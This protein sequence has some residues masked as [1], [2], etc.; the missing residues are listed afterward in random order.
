LKNHYASFVKQWNEEHYFVVYAVAEDVLKKS[1]SAIK[2]F[3]EEMGREMVLYYP[4]LRSFPKGFVY[5]CSSV[6]QI[7]FRDLYETIFKM[8]KLYYESE[9]ITHAKQL[10]E[11]ASIT[12]AHFGLSQKYW[13]TNVSA[14]IK[15]KLLLLLFFLLI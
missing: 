2:A 1:V 13:L 10:G 11:F 3:V 5:C 15:C 12:P 14:F 8:Y 6:E 4:E 9:N 7:L